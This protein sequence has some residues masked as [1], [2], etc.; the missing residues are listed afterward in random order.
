MARIRTHSRI[1]REL[2]AE[3]RREV[4]RLLVEGNATYDEIADYLTGRGYDIS[5]SAVGR[6]GRDFLGQYQRLKIIEDKSRVLIS[7]A[8]DGLPLEE[9]AGKLIVQKILEVLMSGEYDVLEVPRLVSD[10]AKLQSSTVLRERLK[11]EFQKTVEKTANEVVKV[12]KTGGLSEEK[13][14]EIRKR[15]LGIV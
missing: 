3:V 15:I 8:G 2:P 9:A 1:E 4:D 10:F 13:A 11:M 7:E 5:R 14:E 6:Y 12:A